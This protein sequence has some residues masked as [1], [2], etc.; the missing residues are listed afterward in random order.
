MLLGSAIS[1]IAKPHK[2]SPPWIKQEI[3]QWLEP[4]NLWVALARDFQLKHAID[5]QEVQSQIKRYEANGEYL[6]KMA[7]KSQPY[8]HYISQEVQ[9]RGL[10]SEFALIPFIE[11][12]F[13][14]YAFSHAGASGLWQIMP[15]TGK[16]F[17][18]KQ[19]WWYDG[20]RDVFAST[21]VALDYLKYLGEYF[22]GDWYLALA[23]YDSGEGTVQNA[24]AKASKQNKATDF[25][26]LKLSHETKRYVPRLLAL[27]TIINDPQKYGIDLPI[28]K[29]KPYLVP[30]DIGSQMELSHAATLAGI[31]VEE[32]YHLNPGFNHWATSPK[33][34][35]RLLLPIE[36]ADKFKAAL[37]K[38]PEEERIHYQ[39]H[40]VKP[41]ETLT[42]IAR[43]HHIPTA[44]LQHI[45]QLSSQHIKAGMKLKIP[46]TNRKLSEALKHYNKKYKR[47]TY[48]SR[49]KKIPSI[50]TV[51]KGETLSTIAHRY[52]LNPKTLA[53]RNHLSNVNKIR[54]G[55]K[56]ALR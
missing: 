7:E 52:K 49:L 46:P 47:H 32:I 40:T 56:I 21:Q 33:G 10:P 34:P 22:H 31:D 8:L 6:V 4:G 53:Q 3:A 23:A 1:A 55:Q 30:I 48:N 44:D 9:K 29:N 13:D 17:G 54:V 19:T 15:R 20:R 14:P 11:S 43:S 45:N 42:Q 50:H 12:E 27:A 38:L 41:D 25:W 18:L 5:R 51:R 16:G 37:E 35:H 39:Y 2:L 28:V 24:I 36:I 26:S